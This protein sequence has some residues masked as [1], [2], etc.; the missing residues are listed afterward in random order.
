MADAVALFFPNGSVQSTKHV[1]RE[2][3]DSSWR[4]SAAH[5]CCVYLAKPTAAM[6]LPQTEINSVVKVRP[7]VKSDRALIGAWK[8]IA[9][10]W[11]KI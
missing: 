9:A 5:R 3:L 10:S 11:T 4:K 8:H 2:K 1:T 6:M 7:N